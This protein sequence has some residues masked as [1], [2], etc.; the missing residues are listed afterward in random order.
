MEGTLLV[1]S[2]YRESSSAGK[3]FYNKDCNV[4]RENAPE[5]RK[6]SEKKQ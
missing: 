1:V 4:K 2:K 5:K 3:V 6:Y